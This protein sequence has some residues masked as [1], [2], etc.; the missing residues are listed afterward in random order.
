M[1]ILVTGGAGFI[2]SHLVQFFVE[3]GDEVI[4][5]DDLRRGNKIDKEIIKDIKLIK[6][7]VRNYSII[8]RAT[9]SCD[10]VF[11][12]AAVLGVDVVA[13]N[14]LETMEVET[15]GM[16]N[17]VDACT[18]YGIN[19]IVYSSTSGVYGKGLIENA[20]T[21]KVEASPSSSYS[22]AKRFNEIYLAAAYEEKG[23]NS[24]SARLF[25]VYGP[26]QDERMVL[27]RF[28]GQAVNNESITVYGSGKQ[29]R[30]FTYIDDVIRALA[31]L[32]DKV[33]GSEI[34][35]ISKGEDISIQEVGKIV[36]EF[37][38][39]KS[40]IINTEA[41]KSRYDFEVEKRS[42]NSDKLYKAIGYKPGT[43]F[44][45]GFEKTY[46]DLKEKIVQ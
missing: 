17:V 39:S 12:L 23:L 30:D 13:D 33:S 34:F 11:H 24:I 2:G 35:N 42:G 25:N 26:K 22:I 14:P 40:E 36:K 15:V 38:N 7:D 37:F 28:V 41:P 1:R 10:I 20:V 46:K 18:L 27:P 4:V 43:S 9:K 21:E 8:K 29:T 3:R 32:G 5:V 31:D 19:K 44:K 6:G 16:K 45:N